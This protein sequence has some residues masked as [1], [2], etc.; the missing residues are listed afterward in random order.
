[1]WNY[2]VPSATSNNGNYG[3]IGYTNNTPSP[4]TTGTPSVTLTNPFPNGLLPPTGNSLGLISGAG[5]S[6]AFVDQNRTAPR[7]QQYSVDFQRGLVADMAITATHT[8]A[9]G[10]H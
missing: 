2:Q 5:T 9:R 8:G 7:V 6:I 10:A 1:P 3:Q 4:Q